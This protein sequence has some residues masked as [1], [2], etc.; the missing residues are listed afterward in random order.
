V[1]RSITYGEERIGFSIEFVPKS[2][3]RVSIHVHPDG[4]VHVDAP[5][6]SD[7]AEVVAAVRR[8]ARWIWQRLC[9]Y[10]DRTR[11]VLPR[12]YVSGETHFYLGK[13]YVLKVILHPT[14]AQSV[15][16]LRGRLEVRARS[17]DSGKV[18]ALLDGWYRERA[19][20]VFA[21]RLSDCV[22][23]VRWLNAD[24]GF[25]LLTMKTQWGSC[26]PKGK[27]LLNPLLV[28]AP[29]HCVDYVIFHE[30]CHLK[31]HNHSPGFYGLL[32]ALL[33]DWGERKAELDDLA[34]QMLN[35]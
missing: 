13:R 28:K 1:R 32:G 19:E 24:P 11:H 15:K 33:P 23:K 29:G 8:R 9:A 18:R 27:L 17:R 20:V 10:R 35:Q 12:E 14:A 5:S 21:R 16:L 3:R 30:L 22:A 26:S 7:V 4:S 25:R 34:E 31:E 2:A 6:S